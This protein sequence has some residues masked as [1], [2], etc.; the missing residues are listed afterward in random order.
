MS[1]LAI[2]A[3]SATALFALTACGSGGDEPNA[4]ANP[5]PAAASPQTE[6]TESLS[7]I[8][9]ELESV[10]ENMET[11][12]GDPAA[13][14]INPFTQVYSEDEI[15]AFKTALDAS[16]S[17]GALDAQIEEASDILIT[18]AP[19]LESTDYEAGIRCAAHFDA[20]ARL[21][22]GM[23]AHEAQMN[24]KAV[25]GVTSVGYERYIMPDA[26]AEEREAVIAEYREDTYLSYQMIKDDLMETGDGEALLEDAKTCAESFGVAL[27]EPE[28]E[29]DDTSMSGG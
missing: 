2:S 8:R 14:N 17:E 6:A 25:L 29:E 13:N 12:G 28:T 4:T 15:D 24:A 18:Q 26:E 3:V 11:N 10:K 21:G 19:L 16:E 9:A 1:K 20:A 23:S 27:Y 7:D 22:G 5:Q